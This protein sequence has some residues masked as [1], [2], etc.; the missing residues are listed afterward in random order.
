MLPP[1]VCGFMWRRGNT[2][3]EQKL[4]IF[5]YKN[6]ETPSMKG[7][8]TRRLLWQRNRN[9]A[10]LYT[11]VWEHSLQM[12][13]L[14]HQCWPRTPAPSD[15]QEQHL[16]GQTDVSESHRFNRFSWTNSIQN[17][18]TRSWPA[19]VS[20]RLKPS[21]HIDK[22]STSLKSPLTKPPPNATKKIWN[23]FG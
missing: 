22:V 18:F 6:T 16:I 7:V 17:Q 13:I 1:R 11:V 12:K 2:S 20:T 14:E 21:N 9:E 15:R 19:P 8:K 5:S 3:T 23:A 10:C 4:M